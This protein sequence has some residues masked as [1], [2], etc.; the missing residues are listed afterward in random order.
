MA[1]DPKDP[2]GHESGS[3]TTAE[4]SNMD[5]VVEKLNL[6]CAALE[7]LGNNRGR[8]PNRKLKPKDRSRSPSLP[9]PSASFKGCWH[10]GKPGHSRTKGRGKDRQPDCPE[11]KALIEKHKGL[12]DRYEGEYEKWAKKQGIAVSKVHVNAVLG[13]HRPAQLRGPE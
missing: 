10:C 1:G 5:P 11:F 4:S 8:D 13:G 7:K 2:E 12:P 6:V 9:R 3:E